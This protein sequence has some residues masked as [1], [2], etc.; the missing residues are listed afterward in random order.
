VTF[1]HTLQSQTD[2]RTTYGNFALPWLLIEKCSNK[3]YTSNQSTVAMISQFS[4]I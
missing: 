2:I 1:L 4:V 3:F